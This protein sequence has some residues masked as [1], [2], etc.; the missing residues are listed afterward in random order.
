MGEKV[1]G[2]TKNGLGHVVE[3]YNLLGRQ[4]EI[5]RLEICVE[6]LK[7]A[8]TDDGR[9]YRRLSLQPRDRHGGRIRVA[10]EPPGITYGVPRTLEPTGREPRKATARDGPTR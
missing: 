8:G 9:A 1:S 4:C 3:R 2:E 10:L 6:L 5:E 7:S